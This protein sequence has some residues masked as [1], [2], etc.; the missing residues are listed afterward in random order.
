MIRRFIEA[1]DVDFDQWKTLMRYFLKSANR[2]Q[3]SVAGQISRE[4]S[5]ELNKALIPFFLI[6]LVYGIAYGMFVLMLP[7]LMWSV[8]LVLSMITVTVAMTMLVEFGSLIAA[9]DDYSVLAYRPVSSR[10]YFAVK[11]SFIL[12]YVVLTSLSLGLPGSLMMAVKTSFS[13]HSFQ[14]RFEIF[15]AAV[16]AVLFLG[17]S[18]ALTMILLYT[19]VLRFIRTALLQTILSILQVGMSL[20]VFGSYMIIPKMIGAQG[21]NLGT[22]L[23]AWS[24]LLPQSWFASFI[25]L[26]DGG[27]TLYTV[28]AACAG[29]IFIAAVLPAA[30]TKISL[31]YTDHLSKAYS[32]S[33]S[34]HTVRSGR[35][36]RSSLWRISNHE[37]RAM[38]VLL[39]AQFRS[40]TQFRMSLL[41]MIPMMGF[42]L[43]IGL[44][45]NSIQFDPFFSTQQDIMRSIFIYMPLLL[46]P[47]ILVESVSKSRTHLATWIFFSTPADRSQLILSVEK[48]LFRFYMLPYI[49]LLAIC[50]TFL[51]PDIVHGMLHAV[52]LLCFSAVSIKLLFYIYP[53]IPF[54]R[55]VQFAE[56]L[57]MLSI[58]LSMVPLILTGGLV[59]LIPTIYSGMFSYSVALIVMIGSIVLLERLLK[60]KTI[61]YAQKI[62]FQW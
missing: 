45:E 47:V 30:L 16:L 39:I 55:P 19:S 35:K 20:A 22:E 32:E 40:D 43:Y 53:R 8:F 11:A 14:F 15:F 33:V 5:G 50:F 18:T 10:T 3:R 48:L 28:A 24:F 49:V 56:K 21:A 61:A 17:I 12:F 31:S 6:N 27:I 37:M 44:V 60:K 58:L 54:N 62:E 23:P 36:E 7:S 34:K 1:M 51:I 25:Y 29:L 59:Y 57:S 42:Y 2:T 26:A 46:F 41:G 38:S 52:L 4:Q 9:P 13:M